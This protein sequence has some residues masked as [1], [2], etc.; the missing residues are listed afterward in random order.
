MKW[1]GLYNEGE[2]CLNVTQSS[3]AAK[4]GSY[5]FKNSNHWYRLV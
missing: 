3:T 1:M 2:K 5:D 4:G